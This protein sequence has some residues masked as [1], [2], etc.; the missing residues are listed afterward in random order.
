MKFSATI[1]MHMKTCIQ[2][3]IFMLMADYMN[4]S[5]YF[6]WFRIR[7][8]PIMLMFLPIMLCCS[9]HKIY[10]LCSKLCSR[11]KIVLSLLSLFVYKFA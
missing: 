11:I 1:V 9:A 6:W 5:Y 3:S 10:L 2:N 8:R 4:I 7:D